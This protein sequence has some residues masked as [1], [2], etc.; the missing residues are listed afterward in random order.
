MTSLNG[1]SCYIL[2][3]GLL[4]SM[5]AAGQGAVVG[6]SSVMSKWANLAGV[7][8][9]VCVLHIK[10]SCKQL[11]VYVVVEGGVRQWFLVECVVP[12]QKGYS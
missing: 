8:A 1:P 12:R 9:C 10:H 3:R 6:I 5:I 7:R 11:C 2:T 4:P